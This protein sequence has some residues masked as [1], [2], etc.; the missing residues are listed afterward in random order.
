MSVNKKTA[1]T[2]SPAEHEYPI[3]ELII[4]CEALT[5][6]K[7]EVAQGALFDCKKEKMTKKEFQT[8]VKEFLK[9]KVNQSHKK[10]VK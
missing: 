7:K 4:N 3:V 6:Y 2:S 8:K 1:K 5:G 10:E 9:K